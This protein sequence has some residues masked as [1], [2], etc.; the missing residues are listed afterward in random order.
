[1]TA[2]VQ[3]HSSVGAG[4]LLECNTII[5]GGPAS[6]VLVAGSVHPGLQLNL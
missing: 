6:I 1:M 3:P 2:L 5:L 4:R